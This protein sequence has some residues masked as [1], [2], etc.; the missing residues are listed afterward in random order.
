MQQTANFRK[1]FY[2]EKKDASIDFPFL[3]TRDIL[4]T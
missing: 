3:K 4:E 2:Q 1:V